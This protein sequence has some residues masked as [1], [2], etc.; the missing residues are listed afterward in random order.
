MN[1]RKTDLHLPTSINYSKTGKGV[2]SEGV[3]DNNKLQSGFNPES[4]LIELFESSG[5]AP[6][7]LRFYNKS[8]SY[9]SCRWTFGDGGYSNEKDP[10]WIFDVEGEYKVVLKVFCQGW[11]TFHLQLLL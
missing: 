8:T 3:A 9:D 10:E 7:K 2:F 11:K 5:C 6:L 1:C 4:N